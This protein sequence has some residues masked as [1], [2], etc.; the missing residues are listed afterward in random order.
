MGE[1]M[2]GIV[3]PCAA[4]V[5]V[6]LF[7]SLVVSGPARAH[8][9]AGNDLIGGVGDIVAGAVSL[10]L[11]ILTGTVSGPPIIGTLNGVLAGTFQTLGLTARGL[12]RIT[13]GAI[14]IAM[15]LLPFLPLAM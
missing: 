11:N 15:K 2:R 4:L 5:A 3:V 9:G 1:I 7:V 10:P 6:A 13:R 14:P 12:M 8:A